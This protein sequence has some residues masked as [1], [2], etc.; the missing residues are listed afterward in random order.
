MIGLNL[1]R[2]ITRKVAA[3]GFASL[4]GEERE[5]IPGGVTCEV[6]AAYLALVRRAFADHGI[7]EQGF[8][9]FC[10][11]QMLWNRAMAWNILGSMRREP[12]RTL[13]VLTGKGH[14][15]KQAVP[16]EILK[17]RMVDIRV[18]LPE[19]LLFTPHNLSPE[20]TD[21]LITR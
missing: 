3:K 17:E 11:A 10:E 13:V 4:S 9:H 20:D 1:P 12:A 14:A 6:D 19:D 18:I 21:Y 16:R 15:M 8:V 2:E 7:S 5:M